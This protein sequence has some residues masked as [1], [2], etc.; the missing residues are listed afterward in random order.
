M[1]NPLHMRV[2]IWVGVVV[3]LVWSLI[4]IYWTLASSITPSVDFSVRPIQFYPAHPTF[5]HFAKLLGFQEGRIGG[6]DAAGQ[7]R[8]A[9]LN[10]IITSAAATVLCV[11]FSLLGAYAFTRIEFPFRQPLFFAIIATMAIPGIA[12]LIPLFRLLV[13]LRQI[14]TYIGVTL[15]YVSAYIPLCLWLLKGVLD[16]LPP[17]LEEAARMDGAG[18][19]TII[20]RII[21]PIAAPG[22]TAAA[23]LTFLGAWGQYVVPLV[24]SPKHVKPL[25]VMI[26]EFAGKNLIDYGMIMASGSF[27]ILVPCVLVMALNRYLISGLLAGS[28][29]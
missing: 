2:L 19:F 29:K 25:T 6:V 7:F 26:P 10:S 20:T 12:V 17:S 3:L 14:D 4:P 8:L 18:H 24:F 9:L 11:L 5:E 16:A 13:S 27:A 21:A 15:I 22:L 23:I 1:R 28:G